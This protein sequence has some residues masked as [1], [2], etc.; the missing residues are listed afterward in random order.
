MPSHHQATTSCNQ[1]ITV[2]RRKT[3]RSKHA[4]LLVNKVLLSI[5]PSFTRS[6]NLKYLLTV[7]TEI[8]PS[9][10]HNWCQSQR[11]WGLQVVSRCSPEP[12]SISSPDPTPLLLITN[13]SWSKNYPVPPTVSCVYCP[14]WIVSTAESTVFLGGPNLRYKDISFIVW[15]LI[16]ITSKQTQASLVIVTP[17][18]SILPSRSFI[19]S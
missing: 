13:S 11:K 10:V 19:L 15:R 18:I 12:F 4:Q 1:N 17:T 9:L 6:V 7:G 5:L 14:M 2:K 8:N 3:K 16:H